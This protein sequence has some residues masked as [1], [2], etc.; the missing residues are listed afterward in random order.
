M[1]DWVTA[2][3]VSSWLRAQPAAGGTA[4]A[5]TAADIALAV[6]SVNAWMV[7]HFG[8]RPVVA[9]PEGPEQPPAPDASADQA[10]GA[11]MLAARLVRRRN[12]PEGVAAV[13]ADSVFYVARTDADVALLLGLDRP[14]IG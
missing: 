6:G 8:A 10:L 1:S 4:N 13:T 3:A 14:G 2:E 9:Q 12:S 5:A 11:L 7:R